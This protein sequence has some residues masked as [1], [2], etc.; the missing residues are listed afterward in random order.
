MFLVAVPRL[1]VPFGFEPPFACMIR[2]ARKIAR[3]RYRAPGKKFFHP[4]T[5][6]NNAI[7]KAVQFSRDDHVSCVSKN[8]KHIP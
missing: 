2:R 5:K 1:H 4:S 7:R 3:L 8:Q 6:E